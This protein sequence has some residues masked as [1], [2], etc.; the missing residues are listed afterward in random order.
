MDDKSSRKS[1]PT[2]V[3]IRNG[4]IGIY[5]QHNKEPYQFD[6]P[7]PPTAEGIK[8]AAKIRA[9]LKNK[10]AWGVL[11]ADDIARAK[12][13]E[14]AED[15]LIVNGGILFQ[16][17]AQ[18]YLDYSEAG[19]GSRNEY[20]K[21][22]AKHWMPRFALMPIA[23]ITT[24]DVRAALVDIDFKTAKTKNNNLIALRGVFDTAIDLGYITKS[25][26]TNIKNGK[27]QTGIPDPYT[28]AE[29]KALLNWLNK[30]LEGDEHF[31]YLYFELA[32][33]TGCRPSE[34]IAL[35]W[36]DIDWFNER[37]KVTKSRVNS[38]DK[39]TT[40]TH[41]AREVCMNARSKA[42]LERI[43]E[44]TGH[45]KYVLLCPGTDAQFSNERPQRRRLQEA[46]LATKIRHRP[47]YNARHTYATM[48]L[49]DGVN[50]W[51]VA[52]QLGHSLQTLLKKY[53][54][55]IHGDKSKTE[56]AKLNTK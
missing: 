22:L 20:R 51:F 9:D 47:A 33:W 28:R 39:P 15:S 35:T 30:N 3:R 25:P 34:L 6:L 7:H 24:D 43:R 38:E 49:M 2:G 40:K 50:P 1:L 55:W 26:I 19:K 21:S 12:G 42:A 53:A 52:E 36:S 18:K 32:F 17:V 16:D 56:M 48:L 4:V 44:I 5:W 29:M 10:H 41:S 11:T 37:I 27:V 45:Q 54:K 31:Y 46:M 23:N 13:E 14:V 8:A